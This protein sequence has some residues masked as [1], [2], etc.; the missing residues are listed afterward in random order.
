MCIRDSPPPP[1]GPGGPAP[2]PDTPVAPSGVGECKN[3]K[4][5]EECNMLVTGTDPEECDYEGQLDKKW[6]LVKELCP[7]KCL[8]KC[9][10]TSKPT[11]PKPAAPSGP[12]P[13]LGSGSC[14]NK[15]SD[16]ECN[17]LVTGTEVDECDGEGQVGTKWVPIKTLC[18]TKC[19]AACMAKPTKMSQKYP[20]SWYTML[21][22]HKG[23]AAKASSSADE[24]T[25]SV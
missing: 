15:K 8:P 24:W 18:P 5:D 3:K 12:A 7:S 22:N 10:G 1:P 11:G 4:S 21:Q 17:M 16:E 23:H 6:V 14:K 25:E 13:T 20:Q 9:K 19:V 2:P